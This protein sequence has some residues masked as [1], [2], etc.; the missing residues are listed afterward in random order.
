[1]VE[2]DWNQIL[3][4]KTELPKLFKMGIEHR[5]PTQNITKLSSADVIMGDSSFLLFPVFGEENIC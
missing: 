2:S 5:K 4:S 3:I 1:M